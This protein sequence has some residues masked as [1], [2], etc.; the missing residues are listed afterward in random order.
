MLISP[1]RRLSV[2]A[3]SIHCS[4]TGGASDSADAGAALCTTSSAAAATGE[5]APESGDFQSVSAASNWI[6][7]P[8]ALRSIAGSARRVARPH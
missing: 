8:S 5:V 3:L 7:V 2:S 4:S 6:T 1:A